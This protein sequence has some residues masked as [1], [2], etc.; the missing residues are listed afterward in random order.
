MAFRSA[1]SALNH[2]V[3]LLQQLL[4]TMQMQLPFPQI[5]LQSRSVLQFELQHPGGTLAV[6]RLSPGLSLETGQVLWLCPESAA[7]DGVIGPD[8]DQGFRAVPAIAR[9]AQIRTMAKSFL[10]MACSS[11]RGASIILRF[12]CKSSPD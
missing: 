2:H 3:H 6:S 12:E 10:L 7:T 11:V 9:P 4:S 1:G 8:G 5:L